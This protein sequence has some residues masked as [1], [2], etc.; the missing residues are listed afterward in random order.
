M[1]TSNYITIAFLLFFFGTVTALHIDSKN[2]EDT[3]KELREIR[4]KLMSFQQE[5]YDAKKTFKDDRENL[6][7]WNDYIKKVT[8]YQSKDGVSSR[9]TNSNC[10]FIIQN[11]QI[12]N[13][14]A[15][16]KPLL[17]WS[18][19]T[20]DKNPKSHFYNDTYAH[21][22]FESGNIKKAIEYQEIALKIARN[23]NHKTTWFYKKEL[24]RFKKSL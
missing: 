15:V 24:E 10:W 19:K 6:D 8:I 3:Y 20:V 12:H 23:K 7:K 14:S 16:L 18:K 11:Y 9:T 2:Y 1:K 21:I 5:V 4:L 22:L 13:D 17:K